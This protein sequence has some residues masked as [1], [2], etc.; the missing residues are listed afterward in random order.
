LVTAAKEEV[1]EK[2][3]KKSFAIAKSNRKKIS[4]LIKGIGKITS[5]DNV[6]KTCANICGIQLAIVDITAGKPI[7][8]QYA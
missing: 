2:K 1:K 8:Y 6:T 5:M 3:N 7:L 4:S